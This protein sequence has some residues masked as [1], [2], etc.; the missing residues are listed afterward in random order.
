MWGVRAVNS[1]LDAVTS[2]LVGDSVLGRA[3]RAGEWGPPATRI[4]PVCDPGPLSSGLTVGRQRRGRR[5]IYSLP[6]VRSGRAAAVGR[7]VGLLC[8]VVASTAVPREI[9]PTKPSV[10]TQ[11]QVPAVHR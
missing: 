4:H 6:S 2:T 1:W 8:N 3:G 5:I 10:L 9:R 7:P 11:A